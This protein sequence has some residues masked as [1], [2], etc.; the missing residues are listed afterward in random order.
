MLEHGVMHDAWT[1]LTLANHG[2]RL[3]ARSRAKVSK[4][5]VAVENTDDLGPAMLAL[6]P[7]QR[8]FVE[9]LFINRGPQRGRLSAA[10]VAAGYQGSPEA[11]AAH[12]S[13][14][15]QNPAIQAALARD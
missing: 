3:E 4:S 1:I 14:L 12:A 6:L 2:A 11:I 7:R 10:Y 8:A 13:R 15:M 9:A 5:I